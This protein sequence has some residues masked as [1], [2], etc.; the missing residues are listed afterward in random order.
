MS[1]KGKNMFLP[2]GEFSIFLKINN[3]KHTKNMEKIVRTYIKENSKK[4]FASIPIV[5]E[6][7]TIF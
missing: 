4:E 7:V 1:L 3:G 6:I 5:S 2:N